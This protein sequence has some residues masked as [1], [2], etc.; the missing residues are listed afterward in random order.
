M[1][2]GTSMQQT[3]LLA[4]VQDN[5]PKSL[6]ALVHHVV[7]ISSHHEDLA[8]FEVTD[9]YNKVGIKTVANIAMPRGAYVTEKDQRSPSVARPNVQ[10]KGIKKLHGEWEKLV[11]TPQTEAIVMDPT[12][13]PES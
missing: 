4:R 3:R 10:N 8:A 11:V 1:F 6:M 7:T 9:S 5:T 13:T 2:L 12:P